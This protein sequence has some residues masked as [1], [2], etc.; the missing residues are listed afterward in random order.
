VKTI[1]VT[2]A[3]SGIGRALAV[4]AARA[5][6]AVYAVGRNIKALAALGGQVAEEGG[7]I[8]TDATDIS[9]PANGPGLIGRM[10]GAFGRIDVIVNNAG[11]VAVGPLVTQSDEDLRVQYG[12]HVIG[13]VALVREALPAL[14]TVRG[15]VFMLGSGVARVAVGGLGA[16]PSS[17]AALRSATTLLRRELAPLEIAV[18]YV[19]PGAVDTAFMRRAGLPG[20]PQRMLVSPELVARK[21][22]IAVGTRP[23]VLN[24]APLQTAIVT[25]A[26]MLPA[27]TEA[28]LARNPS[29][30]GG[31]PTLAAIEMMRDGHG[32]SEKIALPSTMP[33]AKPA[34]ELDAAPP[35]LELEASTGT[36]PTAAVP[37]AALPDET[38][39]NA[40]AP[41]ATAPI[42][43]DPIPA[44]PPV[45]MPAHASD[46]LPIGE[47]ERANDVPEAAAV[48][49]DATAET[50]AVRWTFEP[51]EAD[52]ATP[53]ASE[54]RVVAEEAD[55][56]DSLDDDADDAL[57]H[58]DEPAHATTSFDAAL[59]SLRRRMER[60]NLD[61]AMIR[62]LLVTDYVIDVNDVAM[63]WAGMPNKHERALT[64]EVFFALAEWGFLAPRADGRYRVIKTADEEAAS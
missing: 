28:V 46:D 34:A 64:S 9:E 26:E 14:R 27:L 30:V 1:L 47:N 53:G 52:A 57:R 6:Y 40:A 21:I 55:D 45:A 31:G 62:S 59:E 4:R 50:P 36:V 49:E 12:T 24:V 3:S 5:G 33:L 22:L 44:A 35:V 60:A 37:E 10:M 16:Y 38:A 8:T 15:H 25:V 39:L 61:P 7:I 20:A 43:H 13:P 19:D 58:D 51:P 29:L 56:D 32:R 42:E 23:R 54:T 17:K 2:G 48:A 11:T 41:G 18:T 63:R